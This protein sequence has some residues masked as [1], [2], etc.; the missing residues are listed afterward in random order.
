LVREITGDLNHQLLALAKRVTDD[1]FQRGAVLMIE[2][3]DVAYDGF[4][5]GILPRSV[6]AGDGS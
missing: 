5:I 3:S 6:S 1:T 4:H 2:V